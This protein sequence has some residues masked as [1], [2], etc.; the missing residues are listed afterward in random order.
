M[1]DPVETAGGPVYTRFHEGMDVRPMRRDARGE[2][3]DEVRAMAEGKVVY[4]S[5]AAGASN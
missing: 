5:Q 3:L 2:P 4:T 1:R